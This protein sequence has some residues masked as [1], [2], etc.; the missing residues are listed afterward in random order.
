MNADRSPTTDAKELRRLAEERLR[1]LPAV[2]AAGC[3]DLEL[4]RVV[5]ELQIHQIELE[6]QNE[7]LARARAEIEISAAKYTDLYQSAPFGYLTLDQEGT[8]LEANRASAVL[9]GTPSAQQTGKRFALH[10][11]NSDRNRFSDF[12]NHVFESRDSLS[13]ELTLARETHPPTLVRAGGIKD[14]SGLECRLVLEDITQVK[15]AEEDRLILNKL[16][17][18]SILA[19][20]IA[21]DFNNLLAVILLNLELVESLEVGPEVTLRLADAKHAALVSRD[22]T[23]QLTTFAKGGARVR[24]RIQLST[25]LRE[26][27]RLALSGSNVE[28]NIVTAE[29][30]WMSEVDPGQMGQVFRNIVLNAREAMPLGGMVRV[31][32]ENIPAGDPTPSGP[33]PH[34]QVRISISDEGAGIPSDSLIKIFDPYFS[35]KQRG[36]QKGMGLGLTICHAVVNQHGGKI[37]VQSSPTGTTF[38]LLLPASRQDNI[39]SQ[40][41]NQSTPPRTGRLL[42]MDDEPTVRTVVGRLL[43][44]AGHQVDLVEDGEQA[45]KFYADALR[46]GEPYGAV[47][48]DLT[49]RGGMGGRETLHKLRELNP[50]L[51]AIAMSGHT[52]H[53]VLLAGETAGFS[54]FLPKPFELSELDK[55]VFK[56]LQPAA[57][58]TEQP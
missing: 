37:S 29:N 11:T 47:L 9:L 48:L 54:A 40:T 51:K 27:T 36:V 20:G 14:N 50:S 19:G 35:T 1:S 42:V 16:E 46:R 31:E 18:T 43:E 26:S 41:S 3:T 22:L 6:M 23:R 2:A 58:P 7:E 33:T 5:H 13:C 44:R 34:D 12:L 45:L 32:A 53:L 28:S 56:A 55:A 24:E 25:L 15:H 8:I 30:L 21:H 38:H 17:S 49:V 10:L 39:Q 57:D 4:R 52:D